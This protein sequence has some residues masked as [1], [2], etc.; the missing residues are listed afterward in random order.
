MAPTTTPGF[1][2]ENLQEVLGP[3]GQPGTDHMQ[4]VYALRC[5]KCS[6]VYGA[7]GSDIWLR[8]CPACSGG[9]PGFPV[10]I[11]DVIDHDP[12]TPVRNPPW[13]RDELILALALYMT[14][15]VSPPGKKSTA[16]LELSDVLNRLGAQLNRGRVEKFRNPNGVYMKMMNFRRFDPD[17]VASGKVGLTRGNKDE[18]VVWAEYAND[19]D[20]LVAVAAAIRAGVDLG[21]I[22][23]QPDDID[24]TVEAAEG[25]ILTRLH[26]TRERSRKLVDQKKKQALARTS[27]LV[28]DACGFD[29]AKTYGPR[30]QGFIEVHHTKPVHTLPEGGTTKLEDL[31]LVCANCH[32]MI[33]SAR[34]W[35]TVDEVRALVGL[36]SD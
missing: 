22:D 20:R 7:N 16:V 26:R 28:C 14:N 17:V 31:A 29:F 30:G 8:R 35:L 25:R 23:T 36:V 9:A 2:N 18:E 32:R 3:T 24:D 13:S 19:P 4:R 10:N 15:P 11:A 27:A 12:D 5:R 6:H 33:H 34:P 21:A 1:V